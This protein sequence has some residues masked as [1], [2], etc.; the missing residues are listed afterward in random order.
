MKKKEHASQEW[1]KEANRCSRCGACRTICP[2]YGVAG[3]EVAVARGKVQLYRGL[4]MG[5][6][7][8]SGELAELAAQCL[9]CRACAENCPS[10]I[11]VDRIVLDLRECLAF[12]RGVP[13]LKRL[14]LERVLTRRRPPL[15][16]RI[17][18]RVGRAMGVKRVAPVPLMANPAWWDGLVRFAGTGKARLEEGGMVIPVKNPRYRVA[19]FYGCANNQF[20]PGNGWDFLTVMASNRI[21]VVV[22]P[23]TC[24]G[25]PHLAAG[26]NRKAQELAGKNQEYFARRRVDAVL[27]DC[28]SCG[29]T[30]K[31]AVPV[32]LGAPVE[33]AVA[34]LVETGVDLPQESGIPPLP[35]T[36]H[37]PCHAVRYQ[38][39]KTQPRK[40]LQVLPWVEIREMSR[41]DRCC[42]G[43]G[44]FALE[45][46]RL[47]QLIGQAK[48]EDIRNTGARVVATACPG[49]QMRLSYLLQRSDPPVRVCHPLSLLAEAYRYSEVRSQ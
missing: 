40:L 49:C 3:T 19:Y 38:G 48:A 25:L 7:E 15:A 31:E 43:G 32:N 9:L 5:L 26:N 17:A 12:R 39:I 33:D 1:V 46:G 24:C 35:V 13:P 47:S 37:D 20:Y 21:E 41:P 11:P 34:F 44:S 23:Q 8:A 27:T 28:A 16:A 18:Q 45:Q 42:G 2:V 22:P 36:Y 29:S 6:L 14:A 30:L 4:S 10:G